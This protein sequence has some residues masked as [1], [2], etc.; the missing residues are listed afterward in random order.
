VDF[1]PGEVCD[2]AVAIRV[3]KPPSGREVAFA[4]PAEQKA[5]GERRQ[6]EIHLLSK[7]LG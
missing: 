7:N 6:A 4:E 3:P 5:E 2:D 1:E